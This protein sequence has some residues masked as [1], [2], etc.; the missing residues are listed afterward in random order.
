MEDNANITSFLKLSTA[1]SLLIYRNRQRFV[2]HCQ[3]S[4]LQGFSSVFKHAMMHLLHVCHREAMLHD[5]QLKLTF[6]KLIFHSQLCGQRAVLILSE[7]LSGQKKCHFFSS[8]QYCMAF[9]P[10]SLLKL[11]SEKHKLLNSTAAFQFEA[12]VLQF[13]LPLH[14]R[15]LSLHS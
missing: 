4:I 9:F 12:H 7:L 2:P 15:G 14:V 1:F 3:I 5:M 6:F 13:A 8:H 11:H 10:L